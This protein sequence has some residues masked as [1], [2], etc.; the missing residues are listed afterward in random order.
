MQKRVPGFIL[1][2]ILLLTTVQCA[3][4]GM[5]E[6]GPVDED[7]P[8]FLRANPENYTT[9]FDREE[10]RIYFDEY[11][12]LE[13]PAQQI[14]I[15]PPMIP[16][17]DIMPLGTARKDIRIEIFDT[18]EENTTYA[19]NFGK[20]IVDNNEGNPYD[21]F[22]YV[23]STG[24]YIDSLSISGKVKDASLK[25]PSETISVMLYEADTTYSD[26]IVYKKTPRYI[27]YSQD[28]TFNFSLE[29]LKAGT[30]RMIALMDNN[31]NYLYNPRREKIGFIDKDISIPT[32]ENFT[33]TVF[34]EQLEFEPK[35]PIHFKGNQLIFGYE[36]YSNLDSIEIEL[37][38]QKTAGFK[39]RIIKD[40]EKDT[41][42]YWYNNGPELDTLKF[43]VKTP[44]TLDTLI[45]RMGKLERD[46]LSVSIESGDLRNDPK[47]KATTPITS[48]APDQIRI[49]DMDSIDVPFETTF[50][51]LMNEVIL[52]FEKKPANNYSITA[53]PGAIT[54]LFEDTNDT[55]TKSM[56][57]KDLSAYG[58]IVI[59]LTNIE[60]Y[61]VIVQ[62]T[63]TKGDIL[64]QQYA[65]N[66]S[67]F[68]FNY[69]NPG[70]I[71]VRVILDTNANQKWD[72]GNFFKKI[73]PE[74][75]EYLKDTLEVRANWDQPYNFS[76]K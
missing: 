30:Y 66:K 18:L 62:L 24:D 43:A 27:T 46:S 34:K 25:E 8:K 70:D 32:N 68:T 75:I 13:K 19:I 22:K 38:S 52:E 76:L 20:S 61:P 4:K 64:A 23:F 7:P 57:T 63:N 58:S 33:L 42:Y 47:I 55:I 49:L 39:S 11:I 40:E 59:N 72:T 5:P 51:P 17:P 50:D 36:G 14:I 15:S 1:V 73:Q 10:I 29:N 37:L 3:K 35:R 74:R 6:G 69:L 41:L 48:F 45:A 28:S 53:L 44:K 65:D 60:Q 9:N 56:V 16:R 54:D 26:S 21:Y 31:D 71:L 2:L 67:S 12:K